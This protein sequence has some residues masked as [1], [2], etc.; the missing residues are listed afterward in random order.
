MEKLHSESHVD[1]LI[2]YYFVDRS[3]SKLLDQNC[4]GF[5]DVWALL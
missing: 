4:P 3:F 1:A 2:Y 5:W